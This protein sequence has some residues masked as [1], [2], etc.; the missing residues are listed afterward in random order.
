MH[1]AGMKQYGGITAVAGMVGFYMCFPRKF[2][3][4]RLL[5]DTYGFLD[6]FLLVCI[7]VGRQL[8]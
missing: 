2:M 1:L 7:F 4:F 8:Q 6:D 3:L 5:F